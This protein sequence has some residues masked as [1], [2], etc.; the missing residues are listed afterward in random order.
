MTELYVILA[1]ILVAFCGCILIF[2]LAIGRL[3][4]RIEQL[5]RNSLPTVGMGQGKMRT[6]SGDYHEIP[7]RLTKPTRSPTNKDQDHG[8]WTT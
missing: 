7:D 3:N 8:P 4:R 6:F 1:V 5:E 2:A